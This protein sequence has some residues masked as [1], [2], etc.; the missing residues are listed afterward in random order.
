[1]LVPDVASTNKWLI[2]DWHGHTVSE[3]ERHLI[4]V[5][6]SDSSPEHCIERR[7]MSANQPDSFGTFGLFG[8]RILQEREDGVVSPKGEIAGRWVKMVPVC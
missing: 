8:I 6:Q 4:Y 3:V 5:K 7:L 2:A 1:M